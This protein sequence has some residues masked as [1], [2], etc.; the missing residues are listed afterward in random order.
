[1]K[2]V[3]PS[4]RTARRLS[5]GVATALVAV[6]SLPATAAHA[7]PGTGTVSGTLTSATGT[8]L[9]DVRVGVQPAS[10]SATV[11]VGLTD[12]DGRYSLP[13]LAPGSYKVKFW[14]HRN[15]NSEWTQWAHQA[16]RPHRATTY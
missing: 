9:A 16:T 13:G 6:L 14:V 10:G 3:T 2:I 5:G 15:S 11:A 8:P 4:S 12:G 7:D 1:M